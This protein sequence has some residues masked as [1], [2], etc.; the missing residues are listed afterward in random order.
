MNTL[1]ILFIFLLLPLAMAVIGHHYSTAERPT[2]SP[3]GGR[4]SAPTPDQS[5]LDDTPEARV[6]AVAPARESSP[7]NQALLRQALLFA[8]KHRR[9]GRGPTAEFLARELNHRGVPAVGVEIDT[10]HSSMEDL[11]TMLPGFYARNIERE[12][13]MISLHQGAQPEF[14]CQSYLVVGI[15]PGLRL[16]P[17]LRRILGKDW[18]QQILTSAINQLQPQTA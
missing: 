5:E 16:Q 9:Y 1:L 2:L 8:A 12:L 17:V 3:R 4:D 18:R 10:S 11:M 14:A 13:V 6:L 7:A 15:S